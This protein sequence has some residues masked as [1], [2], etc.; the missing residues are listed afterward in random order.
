MQQQ[1]IEL[2]IIAP[3][4]NEVDNVG[5]LVDRIRE[6][7]VPLNIAFEAI[8]VDDAG[9]DGTREKLLELAGQYLWLRVVSLTSNSGQTAA[10]DAGFRA[11]RGRIWA[12]VDADMQNDPGE[13]PRLMAMLSA[14]VDMVNG[15]R[16]KRSDNV[17]RLIQTK[18]ANGIR[19]R[20]SGEN[21]KDSACSLKVYK[22]QCLEG[23]TLYKG[24]HRFFPTL[25][26]MRGFT[27]IEVPVSHH[28]RASGVTKYK[29]GSRVIRAFVDLLAVR[30]MK[31]RQLHYQARDL[32]PLRMPADAS[33]SGSS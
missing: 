18:I 5:P 29:F 19:N 4:F 2:S 6:V 3:A 1:A 24:M 26:K 28:P 7:F 11:A 10:M 14:E 32:T 23:L 20:L 13:I 16:Q 25:V 15:W 9:T 8:I 21:I 17:L 30:W 12:T 22:R 27:V 31:K 33:L